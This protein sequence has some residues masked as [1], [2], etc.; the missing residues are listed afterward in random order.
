[1]IEM[2]PLSRVSV[3]L[4]FL[5]RRDAR[6]L[7]RLGVVMPGIARL[8]V[9]GLDLE[10]L[11]R[12]QEDFLGALLVLEAEDVRIVGAFGLV[13]PR[14]DAALRTVAAGLERRLG[15]LAIDRA[16]HDRPVR[17]AVEESHEHFVAD[18]RQEPRAAP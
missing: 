15:I 16:R 6:V 9:L 10:V 4:E 5:D 13:A 14:A 8:V 7:D 18:A 12:V 17:I 2:S 3:S 1:M 11:L